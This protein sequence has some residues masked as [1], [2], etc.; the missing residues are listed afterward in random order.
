MHTKRLRAVALTVILALSLFPAAA[1]GASR[2]VALTATRN[3]SMDPRADYLGGI[4]QGLLAW[5]LSR[6]SGIILVD[7]ASLDRVLAEQ[8]LQ[9]S[10]LAGDP[11]ASARVGQLLGADFLVSLDYVILSGEILVTASSTDVRTGRQS[12]FVERGSTENLVHRLAEALAEH[13]S[14]VRPTFA[15]PASERSILTLRDESPGSIALHSIMRQAEIFLDGE[16]VGYTTGSSETPFVLDKLS[17]GLHTLSVRMGHG[18]GVVLLP[19]VEFADWTATVNVQPGKRHVLRDETRDFNSALYRLQMLA[20]HDAKWKPS[21]PLG[22]WAI[23]FVD[24]S[25]KRVQGTLT[26]SGSMRGTDAEFAAVLVVDGQRLE[27][28]I[29]CPSGKEAEDRRILGLVAVE[30]DVD[31]RWDTTDLDIGIERTDVYQGMYDDE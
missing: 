15:D 30:V 19:Q 22:P 1:Q 17:P 29:V 7:R 21:L 27:W 3:L 18:F 26:L 28:T 31:R 20:S 2:K 4:L 10:G 23:D 14:G 13:Y 12:S 5:D 24:R 25:G 11:A 6:A 8:E 16:F 9:L